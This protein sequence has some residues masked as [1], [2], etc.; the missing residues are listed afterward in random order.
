MSS[1]RDNCIQAFCKLRRLQEASSNGYCRCISCGVLVRWDE[2]DGG[3]WLSRRFRGT[4]IEADNVWPQCRRCN[5][6]GGGEVHELYSAELERRIGRERMDELR[7]GRVQYSRRDYK[8]LT[9]RFLAMGRR[10][11]KEKGL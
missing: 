6:T 11:R 2:C 10:I 7:R 4:E 3:H 5:R 9:G 8:A 1:D